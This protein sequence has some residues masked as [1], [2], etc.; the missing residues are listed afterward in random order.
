MVFHSCRPYRLGSQVKFLGA[1]TAP[2]CQNISQQQIFGALLIQRWWRLLTQRKYDVL[3]IPNKHTHTQ[4][5][6]MSA[7]HFVNIMQ[8]KA[9]ESNLYECE[10]HQIEEVV[11]LQVVREWCAQVE[12]TRQIGQKRT[13][14]LTTAF[15]TLLA[16]CCEKYYTV[17]YKNVIEKGG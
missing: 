11:E 2:K 15:L 6:Y 4:S 17:L 5:P 7:R 1:C 13:A 14:F 3:K 16:C 10:F 9:T 12:K 8:I